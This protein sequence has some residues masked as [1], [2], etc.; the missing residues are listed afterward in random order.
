MILSDSHRKI[1]Y[2]LFDF[3]GTLTR[4]DS[5]NDF[6]IYRFGYVAFILTIARCIH[7]VL[8]S[9]IKHSYCLNVKEHLLSHFYKGKKYKEFV[10]DAHTYAQ[11]RLNRII[12][13]SAQKVLEDHLNK[14]HS[15]YIVTAS[16]DEWIKEWA[17]RYDIHVLSSKLEVVS[18]K[19]TGQF[20]FHCHGDMKMDMIQKALSDRS[21]AYI[22]A[23]GDSPGDI[24]ML[25]L[26]DE[27]FYK[28]F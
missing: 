21:D 12:R 10:D 11:D 1:V 14:K 19:I 17:R 8:L 25:S 6:F 7:F 28:Y 18:G 5:F 26:A 2:V 13:K 20:G 27:K 4:S 23:Y 16:P 3:D 22:Y 24:P 15:I 9:R